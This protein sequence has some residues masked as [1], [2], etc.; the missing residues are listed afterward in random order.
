SDWDRTPSP[1]PAHLLVVYITIV[2]IESPIDNSGSGDGIPAGG[3]AGDTLFPLD[4]QRVEGEGEEG[5]VA[6]Q[7][8]HLDELT[9]VVPLPQPGPGAV[10]DDRAAVELVGGL[11]EGG[12][13]GRQ[14]RCR[15]PVDHSVD[16][17]A[18]AP[19]ARHP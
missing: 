18:Q 5:V 11:E 3:E 16:L 15:R 17:V 12:V 2:N 19:L 7:H 10:A 8:G 13:E 14:P 6:D 9:V 1:W 4:A